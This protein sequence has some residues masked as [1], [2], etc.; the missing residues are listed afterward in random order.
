[1]KKIIVSII[2]VLFAT[3]TF[4]QFV[5]ASTMSQG[6]STK[7]VKT[8]IAKQEISIHAGLGFNDYGYL[9]LSAGI[10]YKY[11]PFEKYNIR[12]LGEIGSEFVI[13]S[14][15][16]NSLS[17]LPILV[18]LN[19]EHPFNQNWS[20]FLDFGLGPN[21]PLSGSR[22]LDSYGSYYGMYDYKIGFTF[23]PE[24]GFAYYKFMFSFKFSYSSNDYTEHRVLLDYYYY[25]GD[26]YDHYD[27]Y[28]DRRSM[29]SF[30]FLFRLGYRF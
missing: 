8:E 27:N 17:V 29:D 2:C 9:G 19:Y 5:G 3:S 1:M 20:F 12:L 21:I 24:I 7:S 25:G 22:R 14:D 16:Y 13:N 28:Y 30:Y 6:G 11:K 18:G 15:Y 10:K 26:Y 4:A 23:S